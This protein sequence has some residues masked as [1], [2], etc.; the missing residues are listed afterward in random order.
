MA[1]LAQSR[2]TCRHASGHTS[3]QADKQASGLT[4]QQVS[5]QA[6]KIIAV[7]KIFTIRQLT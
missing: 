2:Q 4:S 5:R 7:H 3:T 1:L 6:D